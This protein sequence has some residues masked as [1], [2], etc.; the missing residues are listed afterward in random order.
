M[1]NTWALV[2]A[3]MCAYVIGSIPFGYLLGKITGVGD[4]RTIGSGNI[5]ATNMLRT[6]KKGVAA[7]TLLLDILKG[8]LAVSLFDAA[9]FF[10]FFNVYEW[11]L[12]VDIYLAVYFSGVVAVFGHVFP[13]WLRYKGGKG[14]A[15]AI[16]TFFAISPVIGLMVVL[17]WLV[18]FLITRISS[19][20]ALIAFVATTVMVALIEPGYGDVI[21]TAVITVII[22]FTHR[23]NIVRLLKKEEH[24]WEKL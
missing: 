24:R 19:V 18:T 10:I 1:S 11:K 20:S 17:F 16:G 8:Y 9:F 23:H 5:G 2:F 21:Y 22:F 7:A 12:H 15:T 3:Y 14:V 6:G 13:I 4:I